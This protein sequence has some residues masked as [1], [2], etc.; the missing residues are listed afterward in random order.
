MVIYVDVLFVINFFI[1]YLLLLLTKLLAK[2]KAKTLRLL[3]ASF[4][5]GLYS[6][7]MLAD[8]L[9]PLISLLG[10]LAASALLIFIAFGFKRLTVFAKSL[11]IFYFSNAVFLGVILA[12]QLIFNSGGACVNNGSVYFDISAK[13]LLLC[14]FIAYVISVLV[15]KIYNKT[16]AAK[17]IYSL[18]VEKEGKSI[19]LYAFLDS[20]NRLHE[21]FSDYPVIIADKEKLPFGAE[22]VIP[23]NTVGGEGVLKA[24]KPDKIIISNGKDKIETDRVY[25]ALSNVDSKEYSAILNPQLI[26]M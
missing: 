16:L 25:V 24:F 5:G 20:G 12:I 2:R 13:A 21:P 17:E 9:S 1:T 19:R 23:Y 18:C 15:I 26:N 14:A 3:A 8:E 6:L 22:R 4:A 10:K 11:G 7:V